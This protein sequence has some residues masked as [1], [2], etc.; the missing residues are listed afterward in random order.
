MKSKT[1]LSLIGFPLASLV[2]FFVLT[3]SRPIINLSAANMEQ[4]VMLNK[5]TRQ[6]ENFDSIN[7]QGDYSI[8]IVC[9]EEPS[10]E[11]QS[12]K[13]ILTLVQTEVRDNTLFIFPKSKIPNDEDI[14]IKISAINLNNIYALGANNIRVN[15]LKN[16][17]TNINLNGSSNSKIFGKTG[18]L[19]VTISGQANFDAQKFASQKVKL[20]LSGSVMI[21]VQANEKLDI[22]MNGAGAIYYHGNPKIATRNIKGPVIIKQK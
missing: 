7:I 16:E 12:F 22:A 3:N 18:E 10:I 14:K 8:E 19:N 13:D 15:N 5:E 6:V 11:L 4:K 20:D 9:Q 1:I 21:Q 2:I 17:Q